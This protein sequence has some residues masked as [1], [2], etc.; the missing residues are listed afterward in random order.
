MGV[1]GAAAADELKR[2]VVGRADPAAA[3][4]RATGEVEGVS[5]DDRT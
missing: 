1:S 2:L 4:V 3:A 5:F